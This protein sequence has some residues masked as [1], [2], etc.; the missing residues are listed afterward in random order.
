M[1]ITDY[2]AFSTADGAQM[3]E[4][5]RKHFHGRGQPRVMVQER[6]APFD[7]S[8]NKP[9]CPYPVLGVSLGV[10]APGH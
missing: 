2:V 4:L 6:E 9:N 8:S 10:C 1:A 5:M 3:R 7:I